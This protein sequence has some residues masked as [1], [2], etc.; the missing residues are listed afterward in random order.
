[1][2]HGF[3]KTLARSSIFSMVLGSGLALTVWGQS[4]APV[5]VPIAGGATKTNLPTHFPA[6]AVRDEKGVSLP[7]FSPAAYRAE[8]RYLRDEFR[9][10]DLAGPAVK[11]DG[12]T[13]NISEAEWPFMG[14]SYLG[15]A[16]ANFAKYDPAMRDEALEE[17]RWLIDALQ[18]P[19]M[20]GFVA[21][22]FGEPFGPNEIHVAVF[23]HGHFLN[24]AMQ[25][26]EVSG[27][28]RYDVLIERVAAA[29]A[30]AYL[31]TDGPILR[32]YRDMWWITD[33]FPALSA[34]SR[35]DRVFQRDTSEARSRFLSSLKAYYL[36]K[37]TGLFC[38]YVDPDGHSQVQGARGISVMYGL[39]FLKD[40]D[41]SLAASQYELA[42]QCFVRSLLGFTAVR[43]FPSGSS[44][45]S[46][47]DSGPLILGAGPSASGFAI[48]A[49]A[50]NGDDR[51]AWEL[52]KASALV[53]W[54][55]LQNGKLRYDAMPTVGQAVI[56][57]GKSELLKSDP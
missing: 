37:G 18:T 51:T 23:V 45:P 32:S 54:P 52:L 9:K 35:Y 12:W 39:H 36:D 50:V 3:L 57:F 48:A 10:T 53:G 7:L 16:C 34:L 49:A 1:M 2:E 47:I 28:T 14:F 17:M 24:L 33:N 19:R 40:F 22:H 25:Y 15:Y 55:E 31:G 11:T 20:S 4:H 46:D 13:S 5:S 44:A 42:R 6:F 27:D 56:L 21:P 43:E 26:R 29:L 41:A 30:R 38:T 8:F